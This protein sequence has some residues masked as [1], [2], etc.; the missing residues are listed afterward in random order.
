MAS[1]V[2]RWKRAIFLG[3]EEP[4]R[5]NCL[6]WTIEQKA[7]QIQLFFVSLYIHIYCAVIPTTHSDVWD[8]NPLFAGRP[9]QEFNLQ[10][11]N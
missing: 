5:A 8:E 3:S 11:L 6:L 2:I 9:N 10:A 1:W 4:T 7:M